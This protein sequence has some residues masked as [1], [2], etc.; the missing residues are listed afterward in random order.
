[1]SS[2]CA[3]PLP[4]CAP[5]GQRRILGFLDIAA[6]GERVGGDRVVGDVGVT[7]VRRADLGR[8]WP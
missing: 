1:M 8:I 6:N 4:W 2:W 7:F 5:V 3:G